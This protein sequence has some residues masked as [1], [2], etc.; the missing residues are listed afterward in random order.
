MKPVITI[1][2][3]EDDP[4]LRHSTSADLHNFGFQTLE[5]ENGLQA[6]ELFQQERPDLVLTNLRMPVM[7]GFELLTRVITASP[8]TPVIILSGVNTTFIIRLPLNG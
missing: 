4:L 6:W 5:A 1:L 8:D 3:A 2:H 7:D